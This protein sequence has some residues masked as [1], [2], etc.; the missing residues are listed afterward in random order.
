[1]SSLFHMYFFLNVGT[2]IRH[3][4]EKVKNIYYSRSFLHRQKVIM[5]K[6]L[7]KN[8]SNVNKLHIFIHFL[9][10]KQQKLRFFDDFFN[11]I[12]VN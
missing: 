4:V 9:S 6:K 7:S 10:R 8:L 2:K 1:M 3:D 11:V 5:S 12:I